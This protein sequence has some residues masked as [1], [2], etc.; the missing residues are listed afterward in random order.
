VNLTALTIALNSADQG[1]GI[2][3]QAGPNDIVNLHSTI[4]ALNRESDIAPLNGPDLFGAFNSQ[5]HNLYG[6]TDSAAS[7]TNLEASDL[8]GTPLAPLNPRLG[9]LQ[10]NGGPT[11]TLA[12]LSGSP[13]LNKGAP[14]PTTVDQRGHPRDPKTPDIGA[15]EAAD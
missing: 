8:F 7:F 10:N 11:A 3:N 4:V 1:G 14:G 5:G 15:F 9:P 12:L 6:I 2:F 13:A